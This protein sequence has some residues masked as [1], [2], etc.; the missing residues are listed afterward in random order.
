[1]IRCAPLPSLACFAI[2]TLALAG[3]LASGTDLQAAN[4]TVDLVGFS[5]VPAAVTID[6]GETVTWINSEGEVHTTTNGTGFEDPDWGTL[7]N[8]WFLNGP[9]EAVSY[10]FKAPG[11]Y[12]Y[13]CLLHLDVGMTGTVTVVAPSAV[14]EKSWGA[15]K[16][17]Y[18]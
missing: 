16:G 13:F 7:W 3:I 14:E 5:F 15:I 6:A 18:K 10:T 17:L 11:V 2:A 9:E 12:P 4:A 8:F 1:M